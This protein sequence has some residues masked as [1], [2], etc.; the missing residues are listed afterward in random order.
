MLTFIRSLVKIIIEKISRIKI[1]KILCK[2]KF[3][4]NKNKNMN[5]TVIKIKKNNDILSEDNR[6][7][8][9]HRIRANKL[10]L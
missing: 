2:S 7:P 8:K 3:F 10:I 6:I 4:L 5:I 9:K 1:T